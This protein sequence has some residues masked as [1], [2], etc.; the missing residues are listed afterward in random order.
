MKP[1]AK[2]SGS[3]WKLPVHGGFSLGG[4]H[5]GGEA[6]SGVSAGY[7]GSALWRAPGLAIKKFPLAISE[8]ACMLID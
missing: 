7:D 8:K 2:Y 1:V 3:G 4:D 5:F 6:K